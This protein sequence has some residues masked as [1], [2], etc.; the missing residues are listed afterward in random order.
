M[1]ERGMEIEDLPLKG[2]FIIRPKEFYDERGAFCKT[3]DRAMLRSRGVEPGVVEEF[4]SVSKKGVVRGLHYQAEP[5]PQAKLVGVLKGAAFDVIVDLRRRSPTFGKWVSVELS[6]GNRR[7]LYVP[8]GFAHG[9]L[10]L[11]DDTLMLYRVDGD[12]SPEAER[13]IIFD[14][15]S[16]AIPWPKMEYIVSRKDRSWPSFDKADKFD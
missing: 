8:R 11:A 15:K 1:T 2:A 3:Y 4:F 16:L 13:G 5:H 10:S 9:F 7:T 12:Y 6:G 14:D